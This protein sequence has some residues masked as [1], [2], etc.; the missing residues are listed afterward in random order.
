MPMRDA[1][2]TKP[3][4]TPDRRSVASQVEKMPMRVTVRFLAFIMVAALWAVATGPVNAQSS[5]QAEAQLKAARQLEDVAGNLPA[6]LSAYKKLVTASGRAIAAEALL[7]VARCQERLGVAEALKTYQQVIA[8]FADQTNSVVEARRR[9]EA[10]T[11]ATPRS[12]AQAHTNLWTLAP[13]DWVAGPVSHDGRAVAYVA[14][15]QGAGYSLVIHDLSSGSDRTVAR[16]TPEETGFVPDSSA[17]SRDGKQLAYLAIFGTAPKTFK[18]QLRVIDLTGAGL[19]QPRV[20]LESNEPALSGANVGTVPYDWTPD[21]RFLAV[22]HR[23][24]AKTQQIA[25]VSIADG[26]LR[27]LKSFE[28]RDGDFRGFL[29]ADGRYLAVEVHGQASGTRDIL[30]FS[31]EDGRETPVITFPGDDRLMGWAPDGRSL[32]FTS[33]RSGA[34][35]LWKQRIEKGQL[36]G[37]AELLRPGFAAWGSLGVTSAGAL[38]SQVVS[39]PGYS[40]KIGEFDFSNGSF[41]SP[42]KDA[43]EEFVHGNT[44]P[45]WSP[46]G[47]LLAYVSARGVNGDFGGRVLVIR[48]I[49]TGASRE[50]PLTF[51]FRN[52]N[53]R[54]WDW[55]PDN[56]AIV[57]VGQDD[58]NRTGL[59]RIDLSDGSVS[60]LAAA[61]GPSLSLPE[62]SADG[63]T[64][65][66]TRRADPSQPDLVR[67]AKDLRTG[68][69]R[70]T[71]SVQRVS[72]DSARTYTAIRIP[73]GQAIVERD[74]VRG[75]DREILKQFGSTGWR[76]TADGSAIIATTIDP[77]TSDEV[78]L[79][80]TLADGTARTLFRGSPGQS[81]AIMLFGPGDQSLLVRRGGPRDVGVTY[82][83]VPVDGRPAK[84][85][86]ELAGVRISTDIRGQLELH[87]DGRRLAFETSDPGLG[88]QVWVLEG[89]LGAVKR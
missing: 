77:A 22:R 12:A 29:S 20:L 5:R 57:A 74:T 49:A 63:G 52:G 28:W 86:A 76:L 25:M 7:G 35:S 8:K 1:P 4:I 30:S 26:S 61:P 37:Q 73:N 58:A 19:P 9:V 36:Q 11:I 34:A 85:I 24:D 23:K 46:D 66:F 50:L 45:R 13:Q 56:R 68:A 89:F 70:P 72:P 15:R 81:I 87:R 16:G 21:G 65:Y 82:W 18:L 53:Q 84:A 6:A 55:T 80:H 42:P 14:L 38:Y 48:E 51:R 83:W 17:F 40:V 71:E 59:Y 62:W 79:R 60:L 31:V 39:R 75:T 41:A 47:R 44:A 78:V 69:E 54:L 32:L 10:L 64:I 27:V 67:F 88:E 2:M 43:S 33:S 3:H